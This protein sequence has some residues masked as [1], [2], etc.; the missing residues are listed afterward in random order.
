MRRANESIHSRRRQRRRL[1]YM[2]A[3][4]PVASER[5]QTRAGRTREMPQKNPQ[6]NPAGGA[7]PQPDAGLAASAEGDLIERLADLLHTAA[8]A[9]IR[10]EGLEADVATLTFDVRPAA[11]ASF[12]DY[13]MPLMSWAG[14]QRLGR[15]PM[16]I[17]E[18]V[19]ER[20]RAAHSPIIREV[21]VARPGFLN[22]TLDQPSVGQGILARVAAAGDGYGAAQAG[23]GVKVVIEH[24]AINSNK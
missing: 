23:V 7:E 6:K 8:A 16:Q 17:A 22:I 5:R 13:G 24:T 19:A 11:Q 20:L 21:S 1:S 14:K 2:P 15:P 18:G 10:A 3:T 9:Y 4:A 12:G